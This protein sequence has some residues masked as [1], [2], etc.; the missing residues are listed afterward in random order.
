[1]A[2][3][4]DIARATGVT[5]TTVA[6]ALAGRGNVS[7]A[8]R[9][10]ILQCAREMGY[11]PNEI[12]RSF[13][14]RKTMTLALILPTIANPYYPEIAEEVERCAQSHDYQMLLCNTHY[15]DALGHHYLERLVS[16][17][18][19]GIIVMGSSMKLEHILA[20]HQRGLPIVLC[21][22]QE[23]E[24][25]SPDIPQV[26]ADYREAGALAARHLLA[27]GHRDLAII[28]DLPQQ[29]SRLEGFRSA[30]ADADIT[31]S[32]QRIARG[33]SSLDSGYRAARD[34]LDQTPR[35]T[36][37]F[38]TNDWMALGALEAAHSLGVRVPEDLS[39]MGLDDIVVA[40]HVTPALTTI[41]VSKQRLA[42]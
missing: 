12:A 2:T 29:I 19:D 8:T 15:D 6:N 14:Q 40:A 25:L 18:V 16:R 4:Y 34:L 1:M 10:R 28:V 20:H 35:P 33:D 11:R 13:K 21:N 32:P 30:L 23:N 42:Q 27:M 17:W 31:L 37:I 3:I 7:E 41:A 9:Q 5:Q 24:A 39:I 36:A 38:A 26:A 22:W